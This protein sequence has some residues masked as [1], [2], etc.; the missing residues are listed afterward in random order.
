[1]SNEPIC[2]DTLLVESPNGLHLVPCSQIAQLVSTFSGT[3]TL[4]NGD[5]S[6]DAS[7]VIELPALVATQGT[8]LE[9]VATGEG[10]EQI[11]DELKKLFAAGFP[12]PEPSEADG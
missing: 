9:V 6:A 3:V 12:T 5:R 11:V 10:C 1:M 7:R 4:H 8:E 2:R